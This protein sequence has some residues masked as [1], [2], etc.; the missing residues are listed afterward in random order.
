[1]RLA[2]TRDW[3]KWSHVYIQRP[4][5]NR[6]QLVIADR[7]EWRRPLCLL[8]RKFCSRLPAC[9]RGRHSSGA[10]GRSDRG[11]AVL[12]R[13]SPRLRDRSSE[14]QDRSV[15]KRA[16]SARGECIS[17]FR[18]R[19]LPPGME[20]LRDDLFWLVQSTLRFLPKFRDQ[21][22]WRPSPSRLRRTSRSRTSRRKRI[23]S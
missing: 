13:L 3:Y 2:V 22:D 7:A 1:M 5:E 16:A 15:Q 11:V 14:Q 17:A 4:D 19:R 8:A 21:Q 20:W 6:T 10:S 18:R 12:S 23:L 9:I